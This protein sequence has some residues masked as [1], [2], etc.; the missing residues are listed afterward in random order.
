MTILRE[1]RMLGVRGTIFV[2]CSFILIATLP[3]DAV[4][5]TPDQR[6]ADSQ[7]GGRAYEEELP[8]YQKR[9]QAYQAEK[10]KLESRVAAAQGKIDSWL[11]TKTPEERQDFEGSFPNEK[12]GNASFRKFDNHAFQYFRAT[13]QYEDLRDD[14]AARQNL[15]TPDLSKLSPEDRQRLWA[16]NLNRLRELNAGLLFKAIYLED[17]IAYMGVHSIGV[18][19]IDWGEFWGE[20]GKDLMLAASR[21]YDAIFIE[22]LNSCVNSIVNKVAGDAAL[23]KSLGIS[24]VGPADMLVDCASDAFKGLIV[25]SVIAA[26]EVNFLRSVESTGVPRKIATFWWEEYILAKAKQAPGFLEEVKSFMQSSWNEKLTSR[27]SKAA[28]RVSKR[29]RKV[30]VTQWAVN[31]EIARLKESFQTT[32][33]KDVDALRASIRAL[34][35]EGEA[36]MNAKMLKRVADKVEWNRV[37][38][39][40]E[41]GDM[42][43]QIGGN[44][45]TLYLNNADFQLANEVQRYYDIVA[46]LK[47]KKEP[48]GPEAVIKVFRGDPIAFV[49]KCNP[50]AEARRQQD[51]ETAAEILNEVDPGILPTDLPAR[52]SALER[53]ISEFKYGPLVV[54][55][56]KLKK[57]VTAYEKLCSRSP[58]SWHSASDQLRDIR[59][60]AFDI[61]KASDGAFKDKQG[62]CKAKLYSEARSLTD[63]VQ[64]AHVNATES[65]KDIPALSKAL[66][67]DAKSLPEPFIFD[68]FIEFV[69]EFTHYA[70]LIEA[71]RL[72]A[73]QQKTELIDLIDLGL[74]FSQRYSD[75]EANELT[76]KLEEKRAAVNEVDISSPEA[77]EK[78]MDKIEKLDSIILTMVE[79]QENTIACLDNL[80]DLKAMAEEI[81]R[82]EN[83]TENA[84]ALLALDAQ[85]AGTCLA[86]LTQRIIQQARTAIEACKFEEASA[87]YGQ[88]PSDVPE[89]QTLI[90]EVNKKKT[91][92]GETLASHDRAIGQYKGGDVDIAAETI[93]K[94]IS[95]ASCTETAKK[96]ELAKDKIFTTK[97][98]AE[99]ARKHLAQC[100]FKKARVEAGRIDS[101]TVLRDRVMTEIGEKETKD[102]DADTASK[103]AWDSLA[104]EGAN[105]DQV[106]ATMKKAK[107]DAPCAKT[108]EIIQARIDAVEKASKVPVA[109]IGKDIE[110]CRFDAAQAALDQLV[111]QTE[112]TRQLRDRLATRRTADQNGRKAWEEG[113][114]LFNQDDFSGAIAAMQKG[115]GGDICAETTALIQESINRTRIFEKAKAALDACDMETAKSLLAGLP[116]DGPG[117][118]LKARYAAERDARARVN[119]ARSLA[120][121]GQLKSA[122]TK[123][124]SVVSENKACKPTITAAQNLIDLIDKKVAEAESGKNKQAAAEQACAS[125]KPGSVPQWKDT[126]NYICP[127][128]D[129]LADYEGRCLPVDVANEQ[130][131]SEFCASLDQ[132]AVYDGVD[133]A[134][135]FKCRCGPGLYAHPDQP[136]C[137]TED[138]IIADANRYCAQYNGYPVNIAAPGDYV[139]CPHGMQW[140]GGERC[141]P[142]PNAAAAADAMQTFI[143]LIGKMPRDPTGGSTGG[144]S[145]G[146]TTGGG[147]NCHRK[148]SG[149]IHCGGN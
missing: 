109:Q 37:L 106:V 46:C 148:P 40:V 48:S 42:G 101:E 133:A 21:L 122:R 105:V 78:V 141:F 49:R 70:R 149:E 140:D 6:A 33:I 94:A 4:A 38:V 58:G 25:Q 8:E 68:E 69:A 29:L 55:R 14:L 91:E 34:E 99:A 95:K 15:S 108:K 138:Q 1:T 27:L 22:A 120:R 23:H 45:Y 36:A 71:D 60:I 110:V 118:R 65:A 74:R 72:A 80:P 107:T 77:V 11:A 63:A 3:G 79:K 103:A 20:L 147:T 28:V 52:L 124:Q 135:K 145:T 142:D 90:D 84:I 9:V 100:E 35:K 5:A 104:G 131:G 136:L 132:G 121:Q 26:T 119:D 86:A 130:A 13:A 61:A 76:R 102:N 2:L 47:L 57:L 134:G 12:H 126:E 87:A 146:G 93:L 117:G 127:C 39:A 73:E 53:R 43:I 81:N 125:F 96:V 75:E 32:D 114:R 129:D 62:V 128:P 83:E 116:A 64:D 44:L 30:D 137:F 66:I 24:M 10:P 139:C 92:D 18:L 89:K 123:A 67:G 56:G 144:G 59:A 41:V 19:G 54:Q 7:W 16:A 82:L 17:M 115:L 98:A 31:D 112:E 51:L 50:K 85:A 97:F 113:A 88:F 111:V 143:D